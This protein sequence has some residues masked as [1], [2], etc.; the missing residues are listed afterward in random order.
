MDFITDLLY[1]EDPALGQTYNGI[2]VV[3]DRL[4]KYAHFIPYRKT[5]TVLQVAITIIDRC[6]RI[7]GILR[8]FVTDRDKLFTSNF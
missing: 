3:V 4:T 8:K 2:L 1:S 6:F 7:Y 5:F